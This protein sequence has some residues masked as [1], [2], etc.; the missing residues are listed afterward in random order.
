M[1]FTKSL[2]VSSFF[3]SRY[4]KRLLTRFAGGFRSSFKKCLSSEV[5]IP[6][7][8]KYGSNVIKLMYFTKSGFSLSKIFMVE[9]LSGMGLSA[10]LFPGDPRDC[11]LIVSPSGLSGIGLSVNL[12]R[13]DPGDCNLIVSPSGLA[14]KKQIYC[15]QI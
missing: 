13:D 11:N 5:K 7:L 9:G 15:T 3:F 6:Y 4:S 1:A 8:F 10:N 2:M 14:V 12:F